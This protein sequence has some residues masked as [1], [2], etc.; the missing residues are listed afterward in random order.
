M[1]RYIAM[2]V[3]SS[4]R[5]GSGWPSVLYNMGGGVLEGVSVLGKQAGLVEELRRLHVPQTAV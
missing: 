5:A 2:A 1:V 4:R 3:D